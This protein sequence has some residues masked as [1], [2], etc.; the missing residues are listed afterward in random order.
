MTVCD[1][2][3]APMTLHEWDAKSYDAISAPQQAWGATVVERLALDGD[4]TVL[5]AGAGTGRVTEVLLAR[6][7]RG[8]VIAVDRSKAMAD[9]ARER[10]PADQV[11]VICSD[12][13]EF[14][15]PEPV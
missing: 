2:V 14:E 6:L 4:E 15:L 12:L 5:D 9:T 13:L 10:L 11:T 7:P 8:H 1:S 3:R